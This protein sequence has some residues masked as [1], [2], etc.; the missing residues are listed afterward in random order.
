MRFNV[1][2]TGTGVINIANVTDSLNVVIDRMTTTGQPI[3]F[4]N[5]D[6][7]SLAPGSLTIAIHRRGE[8][9]QRRH[10]QRHHH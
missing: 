2:N 1:N 4:T 8:C 10:G 9:E 3:N 7:D 6:L 5:T